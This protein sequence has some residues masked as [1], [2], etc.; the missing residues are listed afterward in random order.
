MGQYV[1]PNAKV[2]KTYAGETYNLWE[3]YYQ[4]LHWMDAQISSW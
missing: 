1:W 3:F 4:R 2:A